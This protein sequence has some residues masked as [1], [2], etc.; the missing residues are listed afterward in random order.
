[1]QKKKRNFFNKKTSPIYFQHDSN[2]RNDEKI[3]Q[4]RMKY[5]WF[6]Y[7][8]YW[9]LLE[10][11]TNANNHKLKKEFITGLA[12]DLRIE[13]GKLDEIINHCIEILCS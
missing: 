9:A 2:A 11:L 4:L 7:G 1:M 12:F 3:L 10:S 6:G 5:D 8:I 13:T